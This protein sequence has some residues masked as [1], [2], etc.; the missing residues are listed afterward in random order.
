MAV[1]V[2]HNHLMMAVQN[3]SHRDLETLA[4]E[5]FDPHPFLYSAVL[6]QPGTVASDQLALFVGTY[7]A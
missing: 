7:L 2:K 3:E 4:R 6:Q 1:G 5:Q